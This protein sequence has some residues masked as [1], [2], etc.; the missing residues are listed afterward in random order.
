M[1]AGLSPRPA[2]VKDDTYRQAIEWL[3]RQRSPLSTSK[4]AT[5]VGLSISFIRT[6]IRL[7]EIKA[8]RVGRG[9][10]PT[11]RIPFT[12]ALR[13]I[14]RLG[15]T[16]SSTPGGPTGSMKML[17]PAQMGVMSQRRT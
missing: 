15:L 8:I 2:T 10:K 17:R 13:Y 3:A 12:E 9:R 11:Y 5:M 16:S 4:L 14:R 6:E 1:R 7:G